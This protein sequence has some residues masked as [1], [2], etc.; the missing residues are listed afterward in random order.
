[1]QKSQSLLKRSST[2]GK[3]NDCLLLFCLLLFE[4]APLHVDIPVL[5]LLRVDD[6]AASRREYAA[7]EVASC[8]CHN[9][10]F[11]NMA[12]RLTA[13][14]MLSLP[15]PGAAIANASGTTWIMPWSHYDFSTQRTARNVAIGQIPRPGV[16][17]TGK[18]DPAPVD[19]ILENLRYADVTFLD[20]ETVLYMRPKGSE[21]GKPDVD[22]ALSDK[23][24]KQQLAK[25]E[26][27]KSGR[28]LWCKT[29]DGLEY[30]I[31]EV[32]VE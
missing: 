9:Q 28:E 29:L 3:E 4:I 32:P 18:H 13:S 17:S 20:D 16:S 14:A 31:G 2:I 6:R 21:A 22:V 12:H 19:N 26:D 1:M 27:T 24:F 11:V 25:E 8:S 7:F 5:Q 23:K 10:H 15:R 30:R